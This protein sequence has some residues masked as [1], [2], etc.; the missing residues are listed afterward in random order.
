MADNM[1]EFN[2]P[3]LIL[4]KVTLNSQRRSSGTVFDS[5][6]HGIVHTPAPDSTL[7]HIVTAA[8]PHPKKE[9]EM[10]GIYYR[11]AYVSI[12]LDWLSLIDDEFANKWDITFIGPVGVIQKLPPTLQDMEIVLNDRVYVGFDWMWLGEAV[13]QQPT[14]DK[15]RDKLI[16]FVTDLRNR[17]EPQLALGV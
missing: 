3:N 8:C 7:H 11:V 15:L 9:L 5:V 6:K 14:E 17:I 10:Q 4:Q 2:N 12:P 16:Q 1:F 13:R